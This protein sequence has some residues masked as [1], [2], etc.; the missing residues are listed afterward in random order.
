MVPLALIPISIIKDEKDPDLIAIPLIQTG[1]F[2][3][4]DSYQGH[5]H[6]MSTVGS[7]GIVGYPKST[8]FN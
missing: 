5:W 3:D 1:P 7:D 6:H 2:N 8:G 4:R